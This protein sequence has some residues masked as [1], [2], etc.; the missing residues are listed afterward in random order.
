VEIRAAEDAHRVAEAARR[1]AEERRRRDQARADARNRYLEAERGRQLL[2]QAHR[3][4]LAQ[5]ARAYLDAVRATVT[6]RSTDDGPAAATEAWLS[7]AQQYVEKLDPLHGGFTA[8]AAPPAPTAEQ[9]HAYLTD[10]ATPPW[11]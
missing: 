1:D 6:G 5:Q 3:W 10:R 4:Q 8:P 7:W 11:R 9:L 2:D